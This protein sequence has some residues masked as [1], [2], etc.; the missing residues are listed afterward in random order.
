MIDSRSL[1]TRSI[2]LKFLEE[3]DEELLLFC[4]FV[5][6]NATDNFLQQFMWTKIQFLDLVSLSLID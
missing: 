6:L 1:K 5:L 2:K 4:F 3:L